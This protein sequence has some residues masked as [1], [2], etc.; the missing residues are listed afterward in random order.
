MAEVGQSRLV[1]G[2]AGR[3]RSRSRVLVIVA[4]GLIVLLGA[5]LRATEKAALGFLLLGALLIG[6]GFNTK[7]LQ[8]YLPLPAFYALYGK[9]PESP[10]ACG[11]G[12]RPGERSL[13]R[14]VGHAGFFLGSSPAN[15][16]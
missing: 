7:M 3:L 16:C 9:K 6:L 13:R 12:E 14:K 15:N 2:A 8:A 11:G 10:A 4:L 1:N 5:F